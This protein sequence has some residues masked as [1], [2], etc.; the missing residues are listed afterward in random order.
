MSDS[1]RDELYSI[2]SDVSKEA[3]GFRVRIDVSDWTREQLL[4]EIDAYARIARAEYTEYA[5]ERERER[6]DGN[7]KSGVGWQLIPA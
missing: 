3:N 1:E 6:R 2:L 7:P 4:A 5:E